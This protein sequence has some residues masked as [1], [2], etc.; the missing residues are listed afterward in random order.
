MRSGLKATRH[1]AALGGGCGGSCPPPTRGH[2]VPSAA[3]EER[4]DTQRVTSPSRATAGRQMVGVGRRRRSTAEPEYDDGICSER[5]GDRGGLR[6][7]GKPSPAIVRTY[8]TL[9]TRGRTKELGRTDGRKPGGEEG[10]MELTSSSYFPPNNSGS[11][12]APGTAHQVFASPSNFRSTTWVLELP[13]Q[14]TLGMGGGRRELKDWSHGSRNRAFPQCKGGR[15]QGAAAA[16]R[17]HAE[18]TGESKQEPW[19]EQVRSCRKP[20]FLRMF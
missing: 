1:A 13:C 2:N 7:S 16:I 6:G 5:P 15:T 19:G 17:D 12:T 14:T 4:G 8:F 18:D 9:E 10:I 3:A 11:V 20:D